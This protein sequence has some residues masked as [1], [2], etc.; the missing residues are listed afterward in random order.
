MCHVQQML[1]TAAADQTNGTVMQRVTKDPPRRDLCQFTWATEVLKTT[2]H[3]SAV[4]VTS[5]FLPGS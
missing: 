5:A 3:S 2:F 1:E 4:P